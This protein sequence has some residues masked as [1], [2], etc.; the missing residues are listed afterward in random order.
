M[1]D[2]FCPWISKFTKS[3]DRKQYVLKEDI[4]LRILNGSDH[5][6]EGHISAKNQIFGPRLKDVFSLIT[7]NL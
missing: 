6:L 2:V 4:I 7:H 5:E 1:A 3:Y